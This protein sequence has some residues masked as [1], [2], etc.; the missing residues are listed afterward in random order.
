MQQVRVNT[1]LSFRSAQPSN[2]AQF[3][4]GDNSRTVE[5]V[6]AETLCVSKD[7]RAQLLSHGLT[8]VQDRHYDK[9]VHL[10]AK[11]AALRAWNDYLADLCIGASARAS[12]K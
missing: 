2:V 11:T 6:L 10:A 4:V 7:T 1:W 5:T 9:G 12:R 8:G 3:S